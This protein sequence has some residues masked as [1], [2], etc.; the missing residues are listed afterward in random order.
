[1]HRSEVPDCPNA[2]GNQ[3]VADLLCAVGG[4]GNDSDTDIIVPADAADNPGR[5]EAD[6]AVLGRRYLI[7]FPS[8]I[9][10]P[11]FSWISGESEPQIRTF[12]IIISH[13]T[14]T[15]IVA[16]FYL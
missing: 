16:I 13:I 15:N 7:P 10:D 4:N 3:T 9:D 8:S 2:A 1:M 14:Q 6:S 11:G 5:Q 12:S